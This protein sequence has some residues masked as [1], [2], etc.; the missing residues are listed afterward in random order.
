MK[1][2]SI[3]GPEDEHLSLTNSGASAV[4]IDQR[5]SVR[6]PLKAG[7]HD[8]VA[9]FL[10]D[11][12]SEAQDDNILQPFI[13]SNYDVLDYRG[14]PVIDRITV[15]GPAKA[16][17]AGDTPSRRRVFVC[18]P[19]GASDEIPCAKKIISSVARRA[20]RR[21]LERQRSRNP[22][23]LLSAGAEQRRQL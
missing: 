8:V 17:G 11:I 4:D 16:T 5:L 6:V 15:E 22:D 1:L 14:E 10:T 20:Y 9:T 13:R 23:G 12:E 3:G 18:R 2:A 21:P 7:P 19:A